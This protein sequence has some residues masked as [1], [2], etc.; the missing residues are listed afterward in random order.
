MR[1]PFWK[2][3]IQNQTCTAT[4]T[5]IDQTSTRPEVSRT[6][7]TVPTRTSSSAI[8]VPSTIVSPTFAIVKM[9][10]RSSVSQK[11]L[12][13]RTELKLS[14]PIHFALALDQLGEAVLA[15]TRA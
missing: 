3:V 11:T 13:C 7:T 6:R 2:F 12:S 5:G 10:V 8:S 9:I 15:G 4:T 14:S 1:T